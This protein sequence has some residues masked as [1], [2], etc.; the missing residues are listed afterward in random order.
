[1][2]DKFKKVLSE[3]K[4]ELLLEMAQIAKGKD[5][6]LWVY[7]EPLRNPSFHVRFDNGAEFVLQLKD[8]KILE[9]KNG[10]K[11]FSEMPRKNGFLP[12]WFMKDLK[13]LLAEE[14]KKSPKKMTNLEFLITMWNGLNENSQ[15]S[16]DDM[17]KYSIMRVFND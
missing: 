8:Y 2:T 17:K 11:Y 14:T 1:M 5:F 10:I 4:E 13:F 12:N 15:I 16:T 7:T 9:V 6:S 3:A